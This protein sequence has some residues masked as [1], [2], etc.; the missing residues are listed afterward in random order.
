MPML[1]IIAI[2]LRALKYF[3]KALTVFA[4]RVGMVLVITF[5]F[6]IAEG[7]TPPMGW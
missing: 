7:K 1:H 6:T 3:K 4:I 2:D 5:T